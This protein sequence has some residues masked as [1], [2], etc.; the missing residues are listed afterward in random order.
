MKNMKKFVVGIII[1]T[2]IYI[3]FDLLTGVLFD[4]LGLTVDK[5]SVLAGYIKGLIIIIFLANY[6]GFFRE[7]K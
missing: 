1:V 5:L 7:D 3:I 2:I 4:S 6:Y